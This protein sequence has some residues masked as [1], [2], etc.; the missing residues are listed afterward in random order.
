MNNNILITTAFGLEELLINEIKGLFAHLE[1]QQ[2]PGQVL[3][4]AELDEIYTICLWSRLANRVLLQLNSGRADS[5]DEIYRLASDINWTQH[6][7]T[8]ESFAVDF[9]G[10]NKSIRNTQFGALKIKDAIVDDFSK[11]QSIRPDVDKSSPDIRIQGRLHRDFAAIYLDMS[12]TSLH[13]RHYRQETG[14]APIRENLAFA[15][16]ERSGWTKNMVL[17]LCDPMCGSGTIA[18]E[19]ALY[20][21]STAP[22]LLRE[23]WGFSH[24]KK[25][26]AKQWQAI[27]NAA[28][29]RRKTDIS[30]IYAN[31]ISGKLVSTARTNAE[32]ADVADM[33]VFSKGD[34]T[35]YQPGATEAGYV[36]SNPPYG[37]RL[38]EFNQLLPLFQ[39]WGS[40]LKAHFKDWKLALLSSNRELLK[41]LKLASHKAY[42]LKNAN[43]DCELLLYSM[44][45]RNAKNLQHEAKLDSDFANRLRKNWQKT[46]RWLKKQN[47]DC[48]RIYDADLPEYNVAI[49]RY[50][51]WLVI[52]EYAPP[53]DVPP[54]KARARVQ[55]IVLTAPKV[56][57]VSPDKI[58]L[59]VREVQKGKSQYEK[60]AK[61]NEFMEVQENG[62]KFSVNLHDYLDTGLFLDHRDTRFK[63]MQMS[64]HKRVLNLFAY[65]GS[66]SV[67]AALGGAKQVTTVDMS[68]TYLDWAK[69][70]FQLNKIQGRHP[71]IKADVTSWLKT[72]GEGEESSREGEKYDLIFIDPPSFSN[73][74]SMENTWDVQ[75]DHV[76]LLTDAR[77]CLADNGTI[78]FSNNLR[79]FKL[80]KSL[81][82]NLNLKV[83]NIS[84]ATIPEDFKRNAKIHHCFLL[85]DETGL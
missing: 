32:A 59:K 11:S 46:Q 19:A 78:I 27:R 35:R 76:E 8:N 73:S 83:E 80:D 28:E 79:S 23:K 9:F 15:M 1:C 50:G 16:L 82:E 39:A 58:A 45:E 6:F 25:H 69:R 75:R 48:F 70:N 30:G 60:V 85:K 51:D 24:W 26:D 65:T 3:L 55:E 22:G 67:F 14:P 68:N 77:K 29:K 21:S 34:A 36:V 52:Q 31:D 74:K 61:R 72:A 40:T 12:G 81:A 57:D 43:I 47:T 5:G 18:I 37:E 53:K 71:F 49:D 17:P 4:K 42:K 33:I 84:A 56:L 44:D 13:Q 41:Q 20:K 54:Q 7:S 66:V 10:T 64:K 62:A 63:V 38:S 2:K